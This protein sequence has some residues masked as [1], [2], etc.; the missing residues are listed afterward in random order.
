MRCSFKNFTTV[1]PKCSWVLHVVTKKQKQKT[2]NLLWVV[3]SENSRTLLKCSW[4]PHSYKN[5]IERC[6][7]KTNSRT[8]PKCSQATLRLSAV[9]SS[10]RN[11]VTGFCS[12]APRSL[13]RSSVDLAS[14]HKLRLSTASPH[15]TSCCH[16]RSSLFQPQHWYSQHSV[17]CTGSS[18]QVTKVRGYTVSLTNLPPPPLFSEDATQKPSSS[19]KNSQ[20]QTTRNDTAR[21]SRLPTSKRAVFHA[22]VTLNRSEG[23]EKE[24]DK[25]KNT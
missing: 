3:T 19:V 24:K 8:V 1:V 2:N 7:F 11:S 18:S 20:R 16:Q 10:S 17:N 21:K 13:A 22:G 23:G 6:N 25:N 5:T 12:K 4:V 9:E 15:L 14:T